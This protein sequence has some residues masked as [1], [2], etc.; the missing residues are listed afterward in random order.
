MT[1]LLKL[2]TTIRDVFIQGGATPEPAEEQ[3]RKVVVALAAEFGGQQVYFPKMHKESK[4]ALH[5]Q[6][7]AEFDG[8]NHDYLAKKHELSVAQIYNITRNKK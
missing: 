8:S 7:I 1:T 4:A 5:H 6:V 2:Q 3:A